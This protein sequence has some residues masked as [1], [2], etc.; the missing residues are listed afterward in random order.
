MRSRILPSRLYAKLQY[1]TRYSDLD[2]E[3]LTGRYPQVY[4]SDVG[5]GYEMTLQEDLYLRFI[6]FM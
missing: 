3:N 2:G 4:L 1:S 5:R 6:Y